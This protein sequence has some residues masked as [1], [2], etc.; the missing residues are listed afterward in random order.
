[1]LYFAGHIFQTLKTLTQFVQEFPLW[2]YQLVRAHKA[3]Q[4]N[5]HYD[6]KYANKI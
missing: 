6:Q 1:M 2:T 3:L 5:I 4:T